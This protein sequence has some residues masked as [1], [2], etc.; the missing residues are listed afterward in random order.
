MLDQM[1][2]EAL[3]LNLAF[4]DTPQHDINSLKNHKSD[5]D[6]TPFMP[7]GI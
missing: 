7:I 3:S 2:F 4:I 5:Q 6:A 1:F